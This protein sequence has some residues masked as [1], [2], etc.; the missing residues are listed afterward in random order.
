VRRNGFKILLAEDNLLTKRTIG[1]FLRDEGYE[2]DEA[3]D[4]A[5]ALSL[6]EQSDYDLVLSDIAMPHVNGLDLLERA[7]TLAPG[8][9]VLLMTAY[10]PMQAEVKSRGAADFILKPFLLEDLLRKVREVLAQPRT[11]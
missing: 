2:V 8:T 7:K 10:S 5:L 1:L 3:E 6:L 11:G 9:P 4:G